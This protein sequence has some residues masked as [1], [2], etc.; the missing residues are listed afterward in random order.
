MAGTPDVKQNGVSALM[1]RSR[2][3]G[4]GGEELPGDHIFGYGFEDKTNQLVTNG[5]EQ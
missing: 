1:L 4:G 2:G 3:R 5:A